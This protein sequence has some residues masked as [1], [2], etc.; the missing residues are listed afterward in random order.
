MDKIALK[1]FPYRQDAKNQSFPIIPLRFYHNNTTIDSAALIDS[2]AT[3][4]VF[5]KEVAKQLGIEIEKG[6]EIYLGGV[7]GHIKGYIHRLKIQIAGKEFL[8]PVVFSH[9]YLVSFNLLGRQEFF[10][11]FRIIF[12]E[13]KKL[14][15]LE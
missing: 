12:E 4:S 10:K 1:V 7:G 3:V 13:K 11:R 8:C 6:I 2:G 9:E 14:L 15:K 5:K